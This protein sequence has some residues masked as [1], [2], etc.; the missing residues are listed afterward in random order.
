M[1]KI[2]HSFQSPVLPEVFQFLAEYRYVRAVFPFLSDKVAPTENKNCVQR[3]GES[4]KRL[5]VAFVP[6]GFGI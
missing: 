2:F 6:R 4:G 5:L 1:R 3:V